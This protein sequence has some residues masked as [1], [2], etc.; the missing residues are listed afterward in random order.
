MA[1]LNVMSDLLGFTKGHA[2]NAAVSNAVNAPVESL[3][4]SLEKLGADFAKSQ[5]ASEL[6]SLGYP[7]TLD[8]VAQLIDDKI[9]AVIQESSFSGAAK[10]DLE[11]TL[12]AL[13]V[14]IKPHIPQIA[15]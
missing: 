4:S 10:A 6:V 8:G 11:A 1:A 9:N 7:P 2:V 15:L 12:A 13:F 5:A 3:E 14:L